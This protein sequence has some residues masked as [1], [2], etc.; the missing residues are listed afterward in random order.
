MF[1][2]PLPRSFQCLNQL[3]HLELKINQEVVVKE[4]L[5]IGH[6]VNFLGLEISIFAFCINTIFQFFVFM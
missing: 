2:K 5:E 3:T 4:V 6:K 1:A